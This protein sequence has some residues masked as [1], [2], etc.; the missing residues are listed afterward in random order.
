MVSLFANDERERKLDRIGDPLAALDASVDFKATAK[1]VEALLPV[2][3]YSKGGRPPFSVLLL[4]KMLVLKQLYN[5]SDDQVEY[6]ALDRVTFQR[7]LDLKSSSR[8]PDSKTFWA[9]QQTLVKAEAGPVI[10]EATARRRGISATP[11]R[12]CSRQTSRR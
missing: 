4:V 11:P 7:F 3:D 8:V 5:L 12:S 9:F 1:A 10:A 2:V 6:Q